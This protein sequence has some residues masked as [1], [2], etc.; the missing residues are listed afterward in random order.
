M[1]LEEAFNF[2][3]NFS[4]RFLQVSF[5]RSYISR[6]LMPHSEWL[7]FSPLTQ[8][9]QLSSK[10]AEPLKKIVLKYLFKYI[11]TKRPHSYQKHGILASCCKLKQDSR[12][13][14]QYQIQTAWKFHCAIDDTIIQKKDISQRRDIIML[15]IYY[16]EKNCCLN[17]FTESKLQIGLHRL[18][19]LGQLTLSSVSAMGTSKVLTALRLPVH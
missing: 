9:P 4:E 1:N 3:P 8:S 6:S 13:H 16:E 5:I 2:L 19:L 10:Q 17:L 18:T 15:K 12:L 14:Q 7:P 11:Q